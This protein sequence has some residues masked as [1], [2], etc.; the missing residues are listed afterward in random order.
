MQSMARHRASGHT[1]GVSRELWQA[2]RVELLRIRG[3]RRHFTRMSAPTFHLN[4]SHPEICCADISPGCLTSR[5]S[6][7]SPFHPDV[8][9][10]DICIRRL[11]PDGKGRRFNFSDW[12]YPDPLIAPTRRV[13]QIFCT[14]P[15]CSPEASRYVP[16]T[17]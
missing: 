1:I 17:F 9:H 12:I 4:V 7:A 5:I 8:L 11:T 10:P 3:A 14:M 15:Q 6:A 13:S 16:P 2:V